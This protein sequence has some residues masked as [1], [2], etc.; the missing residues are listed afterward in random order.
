MTCERAATHA[1]NNAQQNGRAEHSEYAVH[2]IS[3]QRE[4]SVHEANIP[5]RIQNNGRWSQEPIGGNITNKQAH[6]GYCQHFFDDRYLLS[7][8]TRKKLV[9]RDASEPNANKRNM[10]PRRNQTEELQSHKHRAAR[11]QHQKHQHDQKPRDKSVFLRHDQ[12]AELEKINKERRKRN[13]SETLHHK[14]I[15]W[16]SCTYGQSVAIMPR[17]CT[18]WRWLGLMASIGAPSRFS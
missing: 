16:L 8:K 3:T 6:Q 9:K 5:R 7:R 2:D 10:E 12:R 17:S 15:A 11:P 13:P 4:G 14:P 1:I 18:I